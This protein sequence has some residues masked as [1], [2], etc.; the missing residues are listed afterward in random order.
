M[1][2]ELLQN[3]EAK[4]GHV[5]LIGAGPGAEDLL[6]LRAH[7]ILQ[8]ADVVLYDALVSEEILRLARRDAEKISVGKRKGCHS[9]S[10]DQINALIV[11]QT[12]MG[13]Q[14]VRLKSG[15]PMIFGRAGEE[16]A[17]MR[18][19]NVAYEIVPG[20]T[21]ALAAAAEAEIPLT[22]RGTASSVVF[23]TGHDLKSETLPDWA[24]LALS[25]A[26]IA[27]YM[28]RSV[29][30]SVAGRLNKAGLTLDTPV[31]VLENV[32]RKDKTTSIGTLKD[33]ISANETNITWNGKAA[34]ILIGEAVAGACLDE[35]EIMAQQNASQHQNA[36]V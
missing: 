12:Q 19:A 5:S 1:A 23:T 4:L 36:L 10:Q 18:A 35:I 21:T 9:K 11:E 3:P 33:L 17:A 30:Q 2:D 27:V 24:G 25:G 29:A 31:A 20:I 15:D 6:T 14:V 28:G 8:N 22:L 32:S 26:T 7:R 34:L 13:K 16:I